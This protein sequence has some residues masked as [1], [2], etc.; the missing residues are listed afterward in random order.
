MAAATT[1]HPAT[2]QPCHPGFYTARVP[3]VISPSLRCTSARMTMPAVAAP[4]PDHGNGSIQIPGAAPIMWMP[5]AMSP[6]H[7]RQAPPAGG[8][9]LLAPPQRASFEQNVRTQS[10]VSHPQALPQQHAPPTQQAPPRQQV[11]PQPGS[12][13]ERVQQAHAVFLREAAHGAGK[14]SLTSTPRMVMPTSGNQPMVSGD[15][16]HAR[17]EQESDLLD[18]I[19]LKVCH[20]LDGSGT[21]HVQLVSLGSLC[22][23]KLSFKEL[24]RE[25][26]TLPF[27]WIRTR[28]EGLLH[29][30][31]ND[32]AGYYD[33][34]SI[35]TASLLTVYSARY[36]SFWHDVPH[37]PGMRE[38]YN[39]RMKRFQA[40]D[41]SKGPVLFARAVACTDELVYVE[42]LLEELLECHGQHAYLLIILDWQTQ[43]SGLA[44]VEGLPNLVVYFHSTQDRL[45]STAPYI[46]PVAAGLR[47]V[48]GSTEPVAKFP[49]LRT[50]HTRVDPS[51]WGFHAADGVSSF[52]DSSRVNFDILPAAVPRLS[53]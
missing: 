24:G 39:R 30:I 6:R 46:K 8:S 26:E 34:T 45:P 28:I 2:L 19:G 40:I 23:L 49:D 18:K 5:V 35:K 32:F 22:A 41:A 1:A 7:W 17:G 53:A 21:E 44:T 36:H 47:W 16:S 25:S 51:D 3:P 14:A 11:Q 37:E 38:R 43:L 9:L 29:F 20:V 50:L 10:T 12:Q 4:R 33:Y 27:D 48:V 31:R 52:E 42:E 13:L 15:L